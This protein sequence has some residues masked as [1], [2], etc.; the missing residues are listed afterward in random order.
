MRHF[1]E[2]R[3][4]YLNIIDVTTSVSITPTPVLRSEDDILWRFTAGAVATAAGNTQRKLGAV[5]VVLNAARCEI[6]H[7]GMKHGKKGVVKNELQHVT[8]DVLRM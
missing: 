2:V 3:A 6:G 8:V 7:S 1:D 4:S 5:A